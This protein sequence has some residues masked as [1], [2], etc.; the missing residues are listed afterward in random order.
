MATTTTAAYSLFILKLSANMEV[1]AAAGIEPKIISE[2][3]TTDL[4]F[5]NMDI[6]YRIKG[7]MIS[8]TAMP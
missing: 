4:S 1:I 6:E 5:I 3:D 2:F 7:I 8:F